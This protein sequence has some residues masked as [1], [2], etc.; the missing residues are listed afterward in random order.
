VEE[1]SEIEVSDADAGER[2]DRLLAARL[3][4]TR[5]YVRRLIGRGAV[6]VGGRP[7]VKGDLLRPG[8]RVA[9][10]PFRHP[11]LGPH[12]EPDAPLR[13]LC[14]QG[15][16]IA[17]DKPAGMPTHPL[18]CDET[19]TVLGALLARKPAI[20]GVGEGGVLSGVV[21]RLDTHTSGVLLFALDEAA[22][23]AARQAFMDRRVEKHYVA[24][25]HGTPDA[26][27]EI[28]LRLAHRGPRMRVVTRSGR[29]AVT[30]LRSVRADGETSLVE[31]EMVT[32]VTHQIR[33][34]LAHLG[35]PVVGDA[36]YGP[37]TEEPRH[38]LH[39]RSIHL[40]SLTVESEPPRQLAG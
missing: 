29:E 24:R 7:G 16:L 12:P 39:A 22:W 6:T 13:V 17:V 35:H 26:P 40:G 33:A 5:S 31:I 30:R 28:V 34:T 4:L 2:L 38:W 23:A 8:D 36:V 20:F 1:A 18:D 10:A 27:A 37:P 11:N 25:V 19:G 15:G 21:H 3:E 32:G 9:I 14:E